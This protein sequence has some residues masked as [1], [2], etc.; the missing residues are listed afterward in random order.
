MAELSLIIPFYNEEK[1]VEEVITS[2]VTVLE[3]AKID[4]ELV[5]VDN[6]SSDSTSSILRE[7]ANKNPNVKIVRVEKNEGYG[8]GIIC[9]FGEAFGEYIGF[10]EGDQQIDPLN[11]VVMFKKLKLE[12]LDFC[13]AIRMNRKDS[14]KRK[15]ISLI[16]NILILVIFLRKIYDVNGKPKIMKRKCLEKLNISSKDWFIDTE[17]VLKTLKENFKIGEVY[18]EFKCRKGGTTHVKPNIIFEFIR[19]LMVFRIYGEISGKR[20][21]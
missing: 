13:R 1:N 17:I 4:Y 19:N 6:G 14:L 12:N 9:G 20:F 11:I 18:T 21:K 5:A 3:D 16:Y 2:T 10:S 15:L 8:N 7:L